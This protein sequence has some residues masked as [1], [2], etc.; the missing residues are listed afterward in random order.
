MIVRRQAECVRFSG[1]VFFCLCVYVSVAA[2]PWRAAVGW[3]AL[4]AVVPCVDCKG[5]FRAFALCFHRFS[6]VVSR[7]FEQCTLGVRLLVGGILFG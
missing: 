4:R 2:H 6:L 5:V 3:R 1:A 7:T